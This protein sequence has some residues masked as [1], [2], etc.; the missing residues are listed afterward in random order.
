VQITNN[1]ITKFLKKQLLNENLQLA[2][3]LY[4]KPGKL[5]QE[6]KD[7][8]LHITNGDNSTKLISDLYYEIK[9]HRWDKKKDFN[10]LFDFHKQILEYNS[11]FFPIKGF[12]IY[13]KTNNLTFSL[14]ENRKKILEEIKQLPSIALRNLKS[15]I[16]T[17]RDSDGFYKYENS[18]S[19]F[20]GQY[21]QLANRDEKL[22]KKIEQKMF[23]ANITIDDLNN[24]ADEKENLLG[25][26]KFT[27]N[28]IVKMIKEDYHGELQIIY[29][30]DNIMVVEVS[31]PAGIKD[32]GCNSLWCFTYGNDN[33][34]QW[35]IYSENGFAYVI[36]DFLFKSDEAGFMHVLIKSLDEYLDNEFENDE[37]AIQLFDMGN[38]QK[39]DAANFLFDAFGGVENA[40]KIM[41]FYDQ[42]DDEEDLVKKPEKVAIEKPFVDPNQLSLFEFRKLIRN[43]L[44]ENVQDAYSKWKRKNVTYRGIK[45]ESDLEKPNFGFGG[46]LGKGLYTAAS[47][48]KTMTRD[49]GK[50]YFIVNGRPKNPKIFNSVN[51]WELWFQRNLRGKYDRLSDFEEATSIEAEIQKLGYDGIEIKGREIVNYKPENVKYFRTEDELKNY[52]NTLN[53]TEDSMVYGDEN[54]VSS[55][56]YNKDSDGHNMEAFYEAELRKQI[57]EILSED[58][59][60]L[61]DKG[62]FIPPDNVVKTAQQALSIVQ[63]NKLVQSNGSNEGSGLQKAQS[64]VAKTPVTHSQLKRMKA[65]FDNNAQLVSAEKAAGRN[66]SNSSIIQKWELWGGDAGKSWADSKINSVQSSNKTSKKVR[67]DDNLFARD[68]RLMNPLNT[69]IKKK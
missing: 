8:I 54:I 4:F 10:Y 49:Y 60:F 2:D 62:T 58:F 20:L 63:N 11:N 56:L 7:F 22:R 3:K 12:D 45:D 44:E 41:T 15:D 18:L 23:K 9:T 1:D 27:K 31:G 19:Y 53:I 26:F 61:Y 67:N 55:S 6:D 40:S 35:N 68:N 42:Y 46:M 52:F 32:I 57:Q 64:L 48:N 21:S 39:Y 33:W 51:D 17:P 43:M 37:N 69:R 13:N 65:F 24:F 5:T 47:S 50:R 29:S 30:K 34:K 16:R 66:S 25:G 38:D 28:S 59:R 36:I 14:F